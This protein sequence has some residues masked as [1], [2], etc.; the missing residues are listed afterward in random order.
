MTP[1]SGEKPQRNDRAT[2]SVRVDAFITWLLGT[3]FPELQAV[4]AAF[5]FN[6]TNSTSTTSI[7]IS[8]A[9]KS[10]TVQ[11]GKSYVPGMAVTIAYTTDATKWMR[12]EVTSYDAGTGALVVNVRTIS[13]TTGTFTAWTVS[14]A[15]VEALVGNHIVTVHTGNG[16]GSTNTSRR[17][18]Q[19]VKES[20]GSAM[21]YADSAANGAS[22][23]VNE[24]GLYE[25]YYYDSN[26]T[27]RA[28]FGI[29]VNNSQ[30]TT[31]ISSVTGNDRILYGSSSTVGN[32]T[33]AITR[34]VKL[35]AGDVFYPHTDG[36]TNATA[37]TSCYLSVRKIANV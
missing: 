11:S 21:T 9:S 3:F 4:V 6:A 13:Q 10:L 32:I 2:F 8:I 27:T 14:Q 15:A 24:D 22:F 20:V 25:I 12:G 35:L 30:G 18:F 1:F 7:L 29:T 5:N 19:T 23:A 34:T 33:S 37:E 31:S 16:H 17:R 26:T 28:F 36:T